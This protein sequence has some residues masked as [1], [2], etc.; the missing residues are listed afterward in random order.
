MCALKATLCLLTH[1]RVEETVQTIKSI[2]RFGE[3]DFELSIADQGSDAQSKQAF[4]DMADVF[5]EVSDRE[6]W[7]YGFGAAKQKAVDLASNDW[8]VHA[9]PGE[10]WHENLIDFAPNISG[11]I[12]NQRKSCLA[13]RIM[14]G[15][16]ALVRQ[17][18]HQQIKSVVLND[19]N[20]RVFRKSMMH[21]R[22]LIHE[23][24]MHKATGQLWAEWA[25]GFKPVAWV[26]HAGPS[27]DDAVF[28]ERKRVLYAHLISKIVE[29]PQLRLGTD[30]YWWT[31]YWNEQIEPTFKKVSFEQ[32]QAL[33][34]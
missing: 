30:P 5:T 10:V 7:E 21:F 18:V 25:R 1:N 33:G 34:G 26:E 15:D 29:N 16:P 3:F 4:R 32:W 23:A 12:Q 19:D 24:P 20:G 8:I 6:L 11:L 28:K 9:D 14:R 27:A 22:G 2:R 31:T 17:V 13:F